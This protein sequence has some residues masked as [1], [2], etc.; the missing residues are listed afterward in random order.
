MFQVTISQTF[1]RENNMSKSGLLS[2]EM[3]RKKG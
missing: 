3:V 1:N 2:L